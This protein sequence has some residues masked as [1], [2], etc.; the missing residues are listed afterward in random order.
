MWDRLRGRRFLNLKFKR[1]EPIGPYTV[2][3]LCFERKLIVELDGK[4][5][6]DQ[7]DY[8]HQR[9]LELERQGFSVLRFANDH[10]LNDLDFVLNRLKQ[11]LTPDPSPN[12]ER[13]E[14]PQ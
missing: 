8:D 6:D 7:K 5:H 3:F 12:R 13:G 10:V 9:T 11:T 2:D 4:H 1:Q 14:H